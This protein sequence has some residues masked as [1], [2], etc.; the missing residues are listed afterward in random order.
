VFLRKSAKFVQ[1][2]C[3]SVSRHSLLQIVR[4][5]LLV[6]IFATPAFAQVGIEMPQEDVHLPVSI[7][8]GTATHWKQ[9]QY[10]VYVLRGDLQIKQGSTVATAPEAVL[11]I[12]R[13]EPYTGR[14]SKVI[15]YLEG[16]Q[17]SVHVDFGRGGDPHALTGRKA[18]SL[19]DRAWLGWFYTQAGIELSVPVPTGEPQVKPAIFERG[20]EARDP[21]KYDAQ[22][23][24]MQ[25]RREE[26]A[27]PA[28][29]A[30]P[31]QGRRVR[32]FP[33]SGGRWNFN[34]VFDQERQERVTSATSGV[35][36]VI[37]GIDELGTVSIE[38]DRFVVWSGNV[39]AP[40]RSSSISK[41]TS[42]SG[43]V[44]ASS[45]PTGCTTTLAL[46]R[47]SCSK[48]KC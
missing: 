13:A 31:R 17:G 10:D 41:G 5:L 2:C 45:T 3:A 27:A 21:S 11:W 47:A 29:Q 38:T 8:A 6:L 20:L 22:I 30:A 34:T 46:N 42:S 40:G 12:D 25:I 16:P 24:A 14:S 48:R 36:I 1:Q 19:T 4:L 39:G 44:T 28:A 7:S 9:G 32:F 15:A 23:A 18:Q 37:D 43:R 35:Q 33:R 26:I